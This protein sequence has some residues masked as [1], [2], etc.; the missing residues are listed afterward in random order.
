M[1]AAKTRNQMRNAKRK[2]QEADKKVKR[3]CGED[4]RNYANNLA[5]DAE[6]AAMKGDLGTLYNITRYLSGRSQN[7]NKTI[8][9]PSRLTRE[10]NYKHGA[11]AEALERSL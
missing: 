6:N 11:R 10:S 1:N 9:D 7:T 3:N 5:K 2:Y 4:K 8:K